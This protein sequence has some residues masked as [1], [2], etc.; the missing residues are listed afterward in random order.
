MRLQN[1]TPS[2]P[3]FLFRK[4]VLFLFI[5]VL[6]FNLAFAQGVNRMFGLVGGY[7]QSDNSSNGFLFSTDSSGQNFQ[8]QYQFP[9]AVSGANPQN[10]EMA[11]YNGKLYGTTVAGGVSNLGTIF[12]YDPATNIYTKKFD[13]GS[14]Y[15]VNG[16]NPRG[17][18]LLYNGKFYGLASGNGVN[19]AG[20]IFEWDPSTNVFTKKYDFTGSGGSAPQ[21]SLRLLNGKMYG[22]TAAGGGTGV[23]VVFEW[24]PSTNAYSVL[25]EMNG[26]NGWTFY[27]NLTVYNNKLYG[28]SVQ[29]GANGGGALYVIDPTLPAGSNTTILKQFDQTSGTSAGNNEMIV[30]NNKLYG[31]LAQNGANYAGTL[32]ELDPAT[33]N[34]TVLVNFNYTTTG[35]VPQGKLVQ[36]GSKFLGMCNGGG[37]NGKGTIYEWDPASPTNVVKKYDF[38]LGNY[39]NPINPGSTL[40]LFNSKLYATTYNGGFND[41]GSLF[42]YDYATGNVTK[43][44]NFNTA[45][46][47]RI[48]YGRP[49]LLNGKIYGTANTG[50]QPDAGCIW[51]YDPS[52]TVYSRKFNF[53]VATGSGSGNRPTSSPAA[54]NGKLYGTTPS[55]GTGGWGVFYVFDPATNAYSKADMQPIGGQQPIGE[56]TLYNNKFYGMTSA[57]GTGNNGIIYSYDPATGTLSKL[58]DVQNA[59]SNT[60][61]GGFTIYNNKLYGSTGGGGAGLGGIIMYDPATNTASTV[62]SLPSNGS[63]GQSI[64]NVMTIYNNKLYGQTFGGGS[65]GRGTIFQ[66]DPATNNYTVLYNYVT[67]TP[68]NGF[69]PTGILTLNGNNMYTITRDASAQIQVVQFD[70]ATNN[71]SVRSGYTPAS[72][73]NLPVYH[74]ALSV[75]PAFIANGIS[76]ACEAYPFVVIDATNNNKWVPI[77]NTA[78]DVVAEINANGNN[79]G[80][81]NASAYINNGAVREDA[82]NQLYL[83]RN[84]TITVQNQPSTNVDVRLYIKTS[85]YL[86]LKNAMNSQGQPSGI[87][88]INDISILKNQQGCSSAMTITP[89]KLITANENYEYGYV[90]KASVS[91]FSTFFFAK[92]TFVILPLTLVDFK[93]ARQNTKVQLS[94]TTSNEIGTDRF[95]VEKS[96]DGRTFTFLSSVRSQST[97]GENRY[98][99]I[100]QQP[101]AGKNF[102]RLKMVDADGRF[103]YSPTVLVDF[104]GKASLSVY[105]NPVKD[106]ITI[107]TG[108]AVQS[109]DVLDA[110][111]KIIL[112]WN[113]RADNRYDVSA[114][115][116][117]IYFLRINRKEGREMISISKL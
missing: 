6:S 106:V 18:L 114:L 37:A 44:L 46:N 5:L 77:L 38:G 87:T 54:Y 91:S 14:N 31:C 102:Y 73:Y 15:T 42:E 28:M 94:W 68:G 49:T 2:V 98:Q 53:D 78:G 47:G 33:N 99:S 19:G 109:V 64:Q 12:E 3:S 22:T 83:D 112:R 103:T 79:L 8:V 82:Q 84:I 23:G 48:P 107:I 10:V 90:L 66:F 4:N 65:G 56:P 108:S 51:E 111:G 24:N 110:G 25:L 74:N 32:F 70:P 60:P 96:A 9:V 71:V 89:S 86:A 16:A 72:S 7:P 45:E 1:F 115:S 97:Y 88:S 116:K 67:N 55:G 43:K 85:E 40:A 117:G 62:F 80:T 27:N 52:T 69:D 113:G 61:S 93:A 95:E 30:Y 57:G 39:D 36:N 58:Y 13:F 26:T 75:V 29:G 11:S 17:S 92:N 41:Q 104:S 101:F 100:D 63:L 34:F 35:S 59:G 21:N 76:N 50:P 20:T 105:P 81:V